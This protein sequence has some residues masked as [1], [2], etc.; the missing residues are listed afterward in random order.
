MKLQ[1]QRKEKNYPSFLLKLKHIWLSLKATS[2]KHGSIHFRRKK[3]MGTSK[4]H[5]K[6]VQQGEVPHQN[7]QRHVMVPSMAKR[8][9]PQLRDL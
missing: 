7:S 2:M 8:K 6:T 4:L 3:K 5:L 9:G 1:Q